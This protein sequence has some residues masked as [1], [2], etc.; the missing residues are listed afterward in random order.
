MKSFGL[1][2]FSS[3][4]PF[5]VACAS[6]LAD[7]VTG[8][9]LVSPDGE[10]ANPDLGLDIPT[11]YGGYSR[12]ELLKDSEAFAQTNAA[13]LD[14]SYDSMKNEE[15][16]KMAKA[17]LKEAI[18]KG[19]QGVSR[20]C[21]LETQRWDFVVPPDWSFPVNIYHGTKDESVPVKVAEWYR[22]FLPRTEL[23]LLEG[24]NHSL[25]RRHWDS[26]LS[27]LSTSATSGL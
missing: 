9:A 10:Y 27:G 26:I 1:I 25:I 2:G 3:G 4:G 23:H 16:K 6:K 21:L 18:K 5:A 14:K 22:S 20:D 19:F 24:E 8:L 12:D 11:V 15:R 7:R 17:D 13:N